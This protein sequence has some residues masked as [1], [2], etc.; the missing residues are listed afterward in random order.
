MIALIVRFQVRESPIFAREVE[1]ENERRRVPI[2]TVLSQHWRKVLIGLGFM[3]GNFVG[4]AL[5][6]VFVVSYSVGGGWDRQGVLNAL[7]ISALV[8]FALT[9]LYGLLSDRIGRKPVMIFG[10]TVFA[11]FGFVVFAAVGIGSPLLHTLTLVL[12]KES[13]H[14]R[15]LCNAPPSTRTSLPVICRA[16]SELR[17]ATA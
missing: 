10:I 1:V 16:M 12:G 14:H 9:P 13:V 15:M 4:G 2:V 7:T 6:T 3:I 5:L 8:T 17:N 11:V